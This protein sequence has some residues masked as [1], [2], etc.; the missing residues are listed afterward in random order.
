M[1]S[2][3]FFFPST[4]LA[5]R[6][7]INRLCVYIARKGFRVA[8]G[9]GKFHTLFPM[10]LVG[11]KIFICHVFFR[12]L[13]LGVWLI[14]YCM[15]VRM[16]NRALCI[17]R[18]WMHKVQTDLPNGHSFWITR[19][20]PG[21]GMLWYFDG[22][23]GC[24]MLEMY[25]IKRLPIKQFSQEKFGSKCGNPGTWTQ[26]EI[27]KSARGF[28]CGD[29]HFLLQKCFFVQNVGKTEGPNS[30]VQLSLNPRLGIQPGSGHKLPLSFFPGVWSRQ[31]FTGQRHYLWAHIRFQLSIPNLYV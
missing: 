13:T 8:V 17:A 9:K 20:S 19:V 31:I 27:T 22:I 11:G 30:A 1:S 12:I 16:F 6:V 18:N 4:F 14:V 24:C 2:S 26:N 5:Y 7:H 28:K 29:F 10:H 25:R 23:E 21:C 15:C 3:P